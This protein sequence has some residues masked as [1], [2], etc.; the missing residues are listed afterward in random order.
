MLL[1]LSLICFLVLSGA[2]PASAGIV[3]QS[4]TLTQILQSNES[5]K[6]SDP[7]T[8][9]APTV[10]TPSAPVVLIE[11][12]SADSSSPALIEQNFKQAAE[13]AAKVQKELNSAPLVKLGAEVHHSESGVKKA[14]PTSRS[15]IYLG[16]MQKSL[17]TLEDDPWVDA[18]ANLEEVASYFAKEQSIYETGNIENYYKLANALKLFCNGGYELDENE[19]PDFDKAQKYYEESE[20][21][22][23]ESEPSF[24]NNP[25]IMGIIQN[26]KKHLNEELQYM[27]D[28][29]HP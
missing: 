3:K 23:Q 26:F 29:L 18:K 27:H 17:K 13:N 4:E 10:I 5:P 9:S 19:L 20:K 15:Q 2:F 22:I 7:T 8:P 6:I 21:L 1:R 11:S 14:E 16:I 12:Q 25:E 28:M 24:A